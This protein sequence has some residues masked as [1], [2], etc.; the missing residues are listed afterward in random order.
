[1]LWVE[2]IP[3]APPKKLYVKI[4]AFTAQNVSLFGNSVDADVIS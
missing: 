4:L 2:L 3:F 1:M